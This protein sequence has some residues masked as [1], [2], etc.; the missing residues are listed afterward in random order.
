MTGRL[1]VLLLALCS[2]ALAAFPGSN[3]FGGGGGSAPPATTTTRGIVYTTATRIVWQTGSATSGDTNTPAAPAK[4]EWLAGATT[5]RNPA[6]LTGRTECRANWQG[7]TTTGAAGSRMGFQYSL[8][9]GSTWTYLDG[10]ADGAI[11]GTA[12]LV[13]YDTAVGTPYTTAYA[14]IASA[15]RTTVLLRAVT[16]GDGVVDPLTLNLWLECR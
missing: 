4:Q 5:R 2:T 1:P 3:P 6:D 9:S 12:P 8:D 15:A 10:T 7:V 14:T 11:A 16:S 13:F